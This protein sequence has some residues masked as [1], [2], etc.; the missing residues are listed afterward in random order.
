MAEHVWSVLCHKGCLD[1]YTNQVSLLDVIETLAITLLEPLPEKLPVNFP[2]Q[3]QLVSF[4]TRSKTGV[5]EMARCRLHLAIPDGSKVKTTTELEIDLK[6]AAR[7][8]TFFRMNALPYH[9]PGL[10][11]F[12]VE[13]YNEATKKWKRVARI[14]LEI[15]PA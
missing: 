1:K 12:V 2:L 6:Q 5:P 7:S 4:W 8:R 13:Q 14:P 10:Y 3:L 9:G 11:S 15:Q